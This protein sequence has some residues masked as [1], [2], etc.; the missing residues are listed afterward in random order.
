[1]PRSRTQIAQQQRHQQISQQQIRLL[2][3][4]QLSGAE[5]ES[6]IESELAENP[7]LE[8]NEEVPEE[9]EEENTELLSYYRGTSSIS[10]DRESKES[11]LEQRMSAFPSLQEQLR[12][13]I[14]FLSLSA[15]EKKIGE[16]IIGSLD[17]DGYL[18]RELFAVAVDLRKIGLEVS[19]SEIEDALQKVQ[20]CEPAGI[21]A[22]DLREC[23]LLQLVQLPEQKAVKD[24]CLVLE[25][26][27][28]DFTKKHFSQVAKRLKLSKEDMQAALRLILRLNPKPGE[29]NTSSQPALETQL[30]DFVLRISAKKIEVQLQ[31]PPLQR[32]RI[33]RAYLQLLQHLQK[34][35]K[36]DSRSQETITFIQKRV[37][38]A[39][40]FLQAL[41][42]REQTLLHTAR[43][44][45]EHQLRFLQSGDPVKLRPL[46]LKDVAQKVGMDVSTISRIVNNKCI[47][48]PFGLFPLRY[49]F[50]QGVA[51]SEDKQISSRAL[52]TMI[53]QLID[54]EDKQRPLPDATLQQ[55]LKEKG[56]LIAR[57]TVAKYREQLHI[58]VARLRKT[59]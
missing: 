2:E 46:I 3:L 38:T 29:T 53:S 37:S 6:R 28:E 19:I 18:R 48:T 8:E 21:A 33:S 39:K 58:P 34:R 25:K 14:G 16:Q 4:L 15:R 31:H 30:P 5:L 35:K 50:T 45:V 1:M 59:W 51:V 20:T 23:L 12:R 47:Q 17:E 55:L 24:A 13:Q 56:L 7:T 41:Q 22:R 43:I 49:F 42:Q 52:K 44:I 40:W 11:S 9:G 27:Y 54:N 32:V 10:S 36:K 57:R 26:Y